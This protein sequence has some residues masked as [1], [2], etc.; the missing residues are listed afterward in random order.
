[1]L[2]ALSY[3]ILALSVKRVIILA[4]VYMFAIFILIRY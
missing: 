3:C 4:N 2:A 1:M